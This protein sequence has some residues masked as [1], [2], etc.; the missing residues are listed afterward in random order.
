MRE[1]RLE[2]DA[3]RQELDEVERQLAAL[4]KPDSDGA[5]DS[6]EL[7]GLTLLY[8][9]GRPHQI[10]QLRH[11]IEHA[12]GRLLH[13]DGGIEESSGLIAGLI[14]RAD[15]VFFPS[16]AS[17]TMPLRPSNDTASLAAKLMSRYG[18][19]VW[20]VCCQRW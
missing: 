20:H 13:H 14:S 2:R 12:G 3:Y 6:L 1:T 10:P 8:V 19:R 7:S 11:M 15:R 18:P 17:A 5:P 4:L 9:G 16:I